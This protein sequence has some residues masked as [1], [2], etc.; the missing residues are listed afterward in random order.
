MAFT[1]AAHWNHLESFP[2][3]TGRVLPLISEVVWA[4]GELTA[5]QVTEC[6]ASHESHCPEKGA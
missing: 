1:Q 5:P 2:S 4:Q 3:V 6:E